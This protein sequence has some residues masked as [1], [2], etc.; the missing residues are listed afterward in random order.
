MGPWYNNLMSEQ[1]RKV[2]H[3]E[4][5]VIEYGHFRLKITDGSRSNNIAMR[6]KSLH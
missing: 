3:Y 6:V 1:Q 5:I 2:Q 4:N